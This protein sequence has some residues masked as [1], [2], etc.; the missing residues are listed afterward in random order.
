MKI[1]TSDELTSLLKPSNQT[2]WYMYE[3]EEKIKCFSID[4]NITDTDKLKMI[5]FNQTMNYER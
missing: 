3:E 5:T 2:T 4:S 1:K